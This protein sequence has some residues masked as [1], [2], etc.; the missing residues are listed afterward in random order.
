MI[1]KLEHE[2]YVKKPRGNWIDIDVCDMTYLREAC[3]VSNTLWLRY[4]MFLLFYS[5][6]NYYLFFQNDKSCA[7][8]KL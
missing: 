6:M 4:L 7:F 5:F 1:R 2:T 3:H 8:P